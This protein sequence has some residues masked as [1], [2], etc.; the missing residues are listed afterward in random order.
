M[1][2]RKELALYLTEGSADKYYNC[3]IEA[4]KGGYL[5]F[6][7]N[8]RRGKPGTQQMKTP[9]PVSLS[10]AESKFSALVE[11]KRKTKGYTTDKSG[12]R[13]AGID[14]SQIFVEA[15]TIAITEVDPGDTGHFVPQAWETVGEGDKLESLLDNFE[16]CIQVQPQ[17]L[18][19]RVLT[20]HDGVT[21]RMAED[22]EFAF[23]PEPLLAQLQSVFVDYVLDGYFAAG[24]LT[25]CDG[26]SL[27]DS[28]IGETSPFKARIDALIAKVAKNLPETAPITV[29]ETTYAPDI[30]QAVYGYYCNKESILIRDT[31]AG[32]RTPDPAQ[33][34]VC[35]SALG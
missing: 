7:I 27:G 30:Q 24:I 8:G 3:V 20:R 13:G 5:V 23:I 21:A 18:H 28:S 10:A 31:R 25:I 1:Y 22:G 4:T 19:V 29:A 35:V 11:E 9:E 16:T 17:G 15:A 12:S 32:Y 26:Y 34:D 14:F 6:G 33:P 2:K